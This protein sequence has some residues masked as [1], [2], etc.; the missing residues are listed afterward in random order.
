MEPSSGGHLGWPAVRLAL[1]FAAPAVE[2]VVEHEA[3]A[4]HLEVILK[5]RAQAERDGEQPSRLRGEVEALGVG[6]AHDARE[7]MERRLLQPVFGE[8]RI[9]VLL[10]ARRGGAPGAA[11]ADGAS[12][13][14]PG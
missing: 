12:R 11:E 13:N 3:V 1:E 9:I 6:A 2:R 4:Q 10:E 7:F 14:A 5:A 8:K